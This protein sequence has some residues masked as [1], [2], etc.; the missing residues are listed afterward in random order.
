MLVDRLHAMLCGDRPVLVERP[1]T[2]PSSEENEVDEAEEEYP[3]DEL[4]ADMELLEDEEEEDN[5][6][7]GFWN[8]G[9]TGYATSGKQVSEK[10]FMRNFG[11]SGE[12]TD[13]VLKE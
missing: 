5:L 10:P 11:T 4:A 8:D 3:D 13:G 1:S 2:P 12:A 9:P 7:L 6:L